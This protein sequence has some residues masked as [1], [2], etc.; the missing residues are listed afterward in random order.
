MSG[1]SSL[2]HNPIISIQHLG[3]T[4]QS[5][6]GPITALRD[7]NLD[8][9][10]GEIFG[11]IGMSGAGKS[12]L[13]RC[14]NLLEKPTEGTVIFD[15][16]DLVKLT[17]NELNQARKSMGMIFQ[18]FNLLMQRTALGNVLFPL[19]ISGVPKE[20]A[21]EKAKELLKMVD[22]EDRMLSYPKQLSG[23][24]KQRVAIARALATNPKVLLCDEATSALDPKTTRS[25]LSLLKEIN[26]TLGITIIVI[27]HE[28]KV[29]E[30][31]CT[32]VAIIDESRIA[33][34]GDVKEIFTRPKSAAAKRLVYP[35]GEKVPE[36]FGESKHYLRI[37]FDGRSSYEPIIAN[38]V[39]DC[40]E[41]VN[42][43]YANSKNIKGNAV[44]EIVIQLPNDEE[45]SNKIKNYL[46]EK[47]VTIEIF[48]NFNE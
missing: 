6:N 21:I 18:Q 4:F 30:E 7:I 32:R 36:N 43:F 41:T 26:R 5:K 33:E 48:D 29:I 47:G 15:G 1:S 3:K 24:Q 10:H 16:S 14:I 31:I 27:T 8:I 35:D 44:G 38:M 13:V 28:M 19:E 37:I 9:H 23:G 17:Q 22:L 20:E 25:I 12:T 34:I 11:I 40:N 39:L 45:R 2:E 42:I 46:E